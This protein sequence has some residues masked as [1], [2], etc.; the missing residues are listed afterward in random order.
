MNEELLKVSELFENDSDLKALELLYKITK[1]EL[2]EI[3]INWYN[4]YIDE[5]VRYNSNC[6]ETNE[7]YMYDDMI[8]YIYIKYGL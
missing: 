1:D 6:F 3:L 7:F 8:H 4:N 2:V 5:I